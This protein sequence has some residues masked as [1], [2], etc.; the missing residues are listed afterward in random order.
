MAGQDRVY[1]P[2]PGL[3]RKEEEK[4]L[5]MIIRV[6]QENLT[7]VETKIREMSDEVYEMYELLETEESEAK[8]AL[9]LLHNAKSQLLSLIHIY[10]SGTGHYGSGYG[11]FLSSDYL[12]YYSYKHY[13]IAGSFS[14]NF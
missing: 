3:S 9:T 7:K 5:Q 11:C 1:R 13:N 2:V 10:G 12:L 8:Q 14:E 4:Q 6:A